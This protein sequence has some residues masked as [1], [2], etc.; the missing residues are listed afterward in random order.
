MSDEKTWGDTEVALLTQGWGE[1]LSAAQIAHKITRETG[2][3][4]SRSAVIGKRFR[5]KLPDRDSAILQRPRRPRTAGTGKVAVKPAKPQADGGEGGRPVEMLKPRIPTPVEPYRDPEPDIVVPMEL[6]RGVGE[7]SKTQCQ[8]PFGNPAESDFHWCHLSRAAGLPYCESHA[9]KAYQ[10]TDDNG[11]GRRV[12]I[13]TSKL[14]AGWVRS[15][16]PMSGT[17]NSQT[18]ASGDP[19]ET[20][21]VS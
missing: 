4:V 2:T 11:K 8:W 7:L 19:R 16:D 3:I 5:L 21:D 14:T 18:P 13:K 1:G 12:A 10:P 6:R 9:A 20:E 15:T 17:Q